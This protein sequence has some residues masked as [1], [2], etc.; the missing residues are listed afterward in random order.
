MVLLVSVPPPTLFVAW[1]FAAPL[2]AESTAGSRLGHTLMLGLYAFP[3][4]L[5]ACLT[6]T[7]LRRNVSLTLI[8]FLPAAYSAYL[9]VSVSVAPR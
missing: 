3:A 7:H 4:L 1:F 9:L 5:L 8:D 6:A 2:L